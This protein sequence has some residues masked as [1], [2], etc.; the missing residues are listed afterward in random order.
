[1]LDNPIQFAV[2]REDPLVEAAL[3]RGGAKRALLVASGGCSALSLRA[4]EPELA[5]TLFDLN[6]AQLEL[7]E[8]KR[9]ALERGDRDA[10]ARLAQSGNFESL[11]AGLRAFWSELVFFDGELAALFEGGADLA[12]IF[13]RKY[14]PI[15]FD[16]FFS[17]ALLRA[18]FGPQA[19]Q[20]APRGSYPRYFQALFE[21]GLARADASDNYFLHHVFLGRYL[22][23]AWPPYLELLGRRGAAFETVHGPIDAVP[24]L[25][26]FDLVSLSNLFDWMARDEAE[27][28]AAKLGDELAPGARV[29]LRQL[30][31]ELDPDALFGDRFAADE[32]LASEL[33][34]RD[35]SLFYR[36]LWIGRR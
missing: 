9:L 15:G 23:R 16:L 17:D 35:R 14:W 28:I 24:D 25:S 31:T 18:M 19:I 29:V 33:L 5:L 10:L 30:N 34:A 4:L 12:G 36:R 11:F 22:D 6:P 26:R 21:R 7:V 13:A 32:A 27:R 1:L 2:V 20:H 3:V 8:K